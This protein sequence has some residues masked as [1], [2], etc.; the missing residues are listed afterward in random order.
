MGDA[1]VFAHVFFRRR[2]VS[3]TIVRDTSGAG[4]VFCARLFAR[5]CGHCF[6][7]ARL[8]PSRAARPAA[9]W[10]AQA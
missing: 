2:R 10:G 1:S 5:E 3:L 9:V 4:T 7:G 8:A 6:A